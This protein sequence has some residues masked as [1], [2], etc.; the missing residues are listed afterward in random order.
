MSFTLGLTGSIGMGKSTTAGFFADTGIP[1]WDADAAVHEI[2]NGSGVGPISVLVPAAIIDG[3]V[4][5][6]IL[7]DEIAKND[8][9]L[10]KIESVIHPLVKKHRSDFLARN[11]AEKIV[12]LDIPLLFETGAEKWLDAVLVVTAPADIQESRVLAR[13]DMTKDRFLAILARQTPDAIKRK[14][15]DYVIDTAKG[16]DAARAEVHTLIDQIKGQIDA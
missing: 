7:R 13:K 3:S 9:L 10:S 16:I 1:V 15:A 6:S 11:A 2:Y 4:D 8:D 12:L 14:K 5:R